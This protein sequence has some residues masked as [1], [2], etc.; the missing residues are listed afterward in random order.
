MNFWGENLPVT[1]K[2]T[3]WGLGN[4]YIDVKDLRILILMKSLTK[5]FL[6]LLLAVTIALS[7]FQTN[8]N[9]DEGPGACIVTGQQ[10]RL[11]VNNPSCLI[12]G[13]NHVYSWYLSNPSTLLTATVTVDLLDLTAEGKTTCKGISLP[14]PPGGSWTGPFT[15]SPGNLDSVMKINIAP[16]VSNDV[17]YQVV[18]HVPALGRE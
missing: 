12:K 6:A 2:I 16:G 8:A 17:S 1:R 3:K 10:G 18:G 9:A 15:C 13:D 7:G 4:V 11:N 5:V 14:V